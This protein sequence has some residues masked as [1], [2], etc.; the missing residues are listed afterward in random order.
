[1]K[2]IIAIFILILSSSCL[3]DEPTVVEPDVV[4]VPKDVDIILTTTRPEF[5]EIVV[6]YQDFDSEEEWNYGPRQFAYDSNGNPVPII[7]SFKDY[8]Y[9]TIVGNAY[10]NNPLPSSL[11]VEVF[12]NDTLVLIDEMTG[13]PG[14]YATVSFNYD[15]VE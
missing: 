4:I 15:I 5:D 3:N 8:T 13:S 6:S 11:K 14:D 1:M 9:K 12:I 2:K 7:I 10:R